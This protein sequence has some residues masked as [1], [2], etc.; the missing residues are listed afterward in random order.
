MLPE[1][2]E[3]RIEPEVVGPLRPADAIERFYKRSAVGKAEARER[4]VDD[5]ADGRRRG[6]FADRLLE[7]AIEAREILLKDP[8]GIGCSPPARARPDGGPVLTSGVARRA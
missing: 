5:R 1:P 7:L 2:L 6:R 3:R 4:A 8:D